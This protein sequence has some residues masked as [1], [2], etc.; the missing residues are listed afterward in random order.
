MDD[1]SNTKRGRGRPRAFDTQN[2][3]SRAQDAFW[4][5][6]YAATSLDNLVIATGLNRPSLYSAF[7]DKHALYMAAFTKALQDTVATLSD[8]LSIDEPLQQALMRLFALATDT[9]RTGETGQ[10]GCFFISTAVVEAVGDAEIRESLR[11]ALDEMDRLFED[12]FLRAQ[13]V[14]ELPTEADIPIYAKLTTA[15]LNGMA[16]RARAGADAQTLTRMGR[17]LTTLILDANA[18]QND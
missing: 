12:R 4:N 2:V 15:M 1:V 6:G 7:G 16:V 13:R 17:G 8:L 3:L 14:G 11:L 5:G 10:R 9:Y 18:R